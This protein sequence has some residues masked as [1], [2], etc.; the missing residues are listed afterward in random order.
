MARA[1]VPV[2]GRRRRNIGWHPPQGPAT[3][4][5]RDAVP[6]R[7][8]SGCG[9][10]GGVNPVGAAAR[11]DVCGAL[12]LTLFS[13]NWTML[14]FP[15]FPFVPD[16]ILIVAA[17]LALALKSPGAVEL[18]RIRIRG[19]HLLMLITVLYALASGVLANT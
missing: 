10:A 7:P 18:P 4:A 15:G 8:R 19:V 5:R 9:P 1:V 16:R 11:R 12:A 13:G 14:G 3:A 6:G 17:L 2:G